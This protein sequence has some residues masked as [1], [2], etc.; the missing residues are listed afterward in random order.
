M[1][2]Y[3]SSAAPCSCYCTS[4]NIS[5]SALFA[6]LNASTAPCQLPPALP[7]VADCSP[8]AGGFEGG[9]GNLSRRRD[10]FSGKPVGDTLNVISVRI[11]WNLNLKKYASGKPFDTISMVMSPGHSLENVTLSC[12]KHW[13]PLVSR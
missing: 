7:E 12:P 6:S 5:R 9:R 11:N 13:T 3:P 10:H 8:S 2:V 1:P 4:R